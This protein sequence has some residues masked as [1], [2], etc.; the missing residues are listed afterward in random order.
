MCVTNITSK[1]NGGNAAQLF[2][3][4]ADI[5][6]SQKLD[7][8]SDVAI[9]SNQNKSVSIKKHRCRSRRAKTAKNHTRLFVVHD[10]HDHAQE[11][12]D[13]SDHSFRCDESLRY[14]DALF[15]VKLHY[16]LADAEQYRWEHIIS[17]SPH[18]RCFAI[19]NPVA[20][21]SQIMPK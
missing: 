7:K 18:G 13:C 19:K 5:I 20:F 3:P 11:D 15:P 14:P 2:K 8:P 21:V 12:P 4:I 9:V 6:P 1:R 10:Y 16:V 17:W